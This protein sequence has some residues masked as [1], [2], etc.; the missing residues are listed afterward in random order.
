M[1]KV[2][3]KK[4]RENRDKRE[5]RQGRKCNEKLERKFVKFLG[6]LCGELKQFRKMVV[7]VRNGEEKEQQGQG[8]MGLR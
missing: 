2:F 6:E 1:K 8:K 4:V 3:R 5:R 7:R